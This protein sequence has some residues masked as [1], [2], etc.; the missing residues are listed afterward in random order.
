MM[1]KVKTKLPSYFFPN[2]HGWILHFGPTWGI[3]NEAKMEKLLQ[4]VIPLLQ[5]FEMNFIP[6]LFCYISQV[7][8]H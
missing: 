5:I 3:K 7:I 2:S 4:S 6:I 1:A 8:G